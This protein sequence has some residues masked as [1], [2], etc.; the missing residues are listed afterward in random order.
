ME[1]EEGREQT[2]KCFYPAQLAQVE[3]A[4]MFFKRSNSKLRLTCT[5]RGGKKGGGSRCDYP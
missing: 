3:E 4:N 1:G 5:S 2:S